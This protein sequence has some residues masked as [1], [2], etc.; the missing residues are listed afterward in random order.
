MGTNL[1]KRAIFAGATLL[2]AM[3]AIG[4]FLFV[5]GHRHNGD[6]L[7]LY[8][9][10]DIREV[11]VAFNDSD[12]IA[13]M[14]VQE[15]DF[16]K[17]DELIAE[18]DSRRY[19]ARADQARHNVKAAQDVLNRLLNGSRP[20]EIVQA[21]STM[22]A[23]HA[24]MRDAEATYR[25]NLEL[26]RERVIPEQ[27]LDDA[28]ARYKAAAGNYDA[29]RQA[30]ILA[31]KGPRIEDIENGRAMLKADQAALALAERELADTKLYAHS[32]GVIEDRI[33]EPG[34]MASPVVP[35]FT[36]ALTNP[37]WVRAYIPETYLGRIYPGMKAS[38]TTDSYPG[39]A[40]QG[41]IGYIS[42]TAEFTPKNV[43][44]SELRT[45][46]V[47][48]VRVY[49][50]NPQNQLRLGMP[51]TVTVALNQPIPSANQING[52]GCGEQGHEGG[53]QEIH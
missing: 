45:R 43:E 48:Q 33:L 11:Q 15:G 41:W 14:F 30:W 32:E 20:E 16:V 8:G 29:A 13:R 40:F 53:Q 27:T 28:E 42:P 17:P 26:R 1:S 3:A 50:C 38:I 22:E 47:Y 24:T 6:L 51:A 19:A 34:D 18:L 23:L 9:N 25:R 2:V 31:V 12:R 49:A 5:R 46:L 35:V 52:L 21:R 7:T 39:K 36:M 37:L 4:I 44:T 10:V